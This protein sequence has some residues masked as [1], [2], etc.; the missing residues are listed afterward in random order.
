VPYPMGEYKFEVTATID[1]QNE[2]L[3]AA[4]SGKVDSVTLGT[5]NQITLNLAGGTRATLADVQQILN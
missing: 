4:M 3:G 2:S 1:G 5:N